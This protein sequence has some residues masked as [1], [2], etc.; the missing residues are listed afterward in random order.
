MRGVDGKWIIGIKDCV[1]DHNHQCTP[2]GFSQYAQ[3]R[4]IPEWEPIWDELRLMFKCGGVKI[5]MYE[6][7]RDHTQYKVT[8]SDVHNMVSKIRA[9][10]E[11]NDDVGVADWLLSFQQRNAGNCV[12]VVETAAKKTGVISIASNHQ[13]VMFDRFPEILL[14]DCTHKTNK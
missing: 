2:E 11:M 12:G 8:M 10:T 1:W 14:M 7:I 13:R 3:N 4:T 9:E 5:R 6:Y